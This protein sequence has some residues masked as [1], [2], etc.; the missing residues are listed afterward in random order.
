VIRLINV[1]GVVL[2]LAAGIAA[3]ALTGARP[4][5]AIRSALHQFPSKSIETETL[6]DGARALRD[7]SGRLIP[8]RDYSRIA[9]GS[10]ISDALLLEFVSPDRIVAFTQ[11]SQSNELFGHRYQGKPSIDALRELER[12]LEL[13]PDLLIVSTLSAE[14]R[15]QR[16]RDAGLNVF[17]LGQMRGL[18]SFL[19]NVRALATLLGRSE[20]GEL[21][22]S[23]FLRRMRSI[24]A[25]LPANERKTAIQL[26]FY[27]KRIFSS[28]RGTSYHDVLTQA[29]LIDVAAERYE[30]WPSLSIEQVLAL[31][32]EI[33]VTR[34]G[35]GASL[36]AN[37]AL[38]ALRACANDRAG[39]V[40]LPDAL[41]N[42]PGPL[43]LPSAE[44]IHRAVYGDDTQ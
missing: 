7:A 40:E 16:L 35:M 5:G 4:E 28:G 12:L 10:T 9:S 34:D 24:A 18:D 37:V 29:G 26:T 19:H 6:P 11:F 13:Q 15:L 43:M 31:D 8:I 32:P 39:I 1:L 23:G 36:C 27:G 14:T 3:F 21:Y 22:A 41:I 25:Q 20:Q 38:S 30:G 2:A 42:D 17:V 44:L 33:I